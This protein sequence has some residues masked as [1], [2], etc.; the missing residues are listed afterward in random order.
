[1]WEVDVPICHPDDQRTGIHVFT[2][3]ASDKN[4]AFASARRVVDEALEH[5][6]NGREIPVPDHARIDW[7]A[8]GL[9][10]GWELRW[11]R[12]KAHQITL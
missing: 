9:R 11:E 4:A 6:Q 8:R 5:L 2:G 3:L 12:A 10:P 7:A 1:M